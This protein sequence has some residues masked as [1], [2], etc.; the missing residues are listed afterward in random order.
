MCTLSK[1]LV[2]SLQVFALDTLG[3]PNFG[4]LALEVGLQGHFYS[5]CLLSRV[6]VKALL[7]RCLPLNG[8]ILGSIT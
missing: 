6:E 5:R 7:I 2:F 1:V 3:T 4:V 8:P